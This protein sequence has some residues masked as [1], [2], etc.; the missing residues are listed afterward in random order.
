MNGRMTEP[1]AIICQHQL[2][3]IDRLFLDTD[4]HT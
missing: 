4:P 2:A 3:R 1:A